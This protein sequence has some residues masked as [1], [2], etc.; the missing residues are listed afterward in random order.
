M[1]ADMLAKLPRSHIKLANAA[2][3]N[4]SNTA[5]FTNVVRFIMLQHFA[6]RRRVTGDISR[7]E[8]DIEIFANILDMAGPV[9]EFPPLTRQS[10]KKART[11][12]HNF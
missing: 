11:I 10:C 3:A 6:I 9:L 1:L 4:L 7:I 5:G 12:C 2:R 8:A